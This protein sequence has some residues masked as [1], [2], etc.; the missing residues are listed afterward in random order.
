MNK[1]FIQRKMQLL[2][3]YLNLTDELD[4]EGTLDPALDSDLH[5]FINILRLKQAETPEFQDSYNK[6][7]KF[8]QGIIILL[9]ASQE[10]HD[11]FYKTAYKKFNFSEVNET[12]LGFAE[13]T[14]GQGFGKM[15][16]EQVISHAFD[17]VKAGNKE[18][19]IFHLMQLFE[20]NVG[21]DRLSDM[22]STIIKPDIEA[23]TLRVL[24]DLGV[25]KNSY[26]TV[27]FDEQ[28]FLLNPYKGQRRIY[29]LP[30]EILKEIPIAH[31]WDEIDDVISKNEAI[32]QEINT[33][34]GNEWYKFPSTR[35]KEYIRKD[36]FEVHDRCERVINAYRNETA[37]EIDLKNPKAFNIV[38][39]YY[40]AQIVKKLLDENFA[41]YIK[42]DTTSGG[43]S[44]LNSHDVT[45]DMLD[46]FGS[47]VYDHKGWEMIQGFQTVS[48]EKFTQRLIDACC[49]RIVEGN[50]FDI[51]FEP[52][53]GPGPADI[54]VSRGSDKTVVEVKLSSNQQCVHGFTE[55]L[56]RYAEVENAEY[57]VFLCIDKGNKGRIQKLKDAYNDRTFDGQKCPELYLVDARK[58]ESASVFD[59]EM[60]DHFGLYDGMGINLAW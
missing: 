39:E 37:D 42:T 32:R 7:N 9:D 47:F 15:L 29:L 51:S 57:M 16:R 24:G 56:P 22:I 27:A 4:Q 60:G 40:V 44:Q 20:D 13:G 14:S 8:F 28:G 26:P 35:K 18:P 10:K 21:P 43:K 33:E 52:N 12:N 46:Y 55:Q 5:L 25:D 3:D 54:K 1:I 17:I 19:E 45:I 36:I 58:Q 59:L 49:R 30:V 31:S 48:G 34:I 41:F 23:Y 38:P 50:G 53:E 6:I 11:T 2:S